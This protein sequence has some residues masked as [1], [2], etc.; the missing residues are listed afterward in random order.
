MLRLN[1]VRLRGCG[2]TLYPAARNRYVKEKY[3][4]EILVA[5]YSEAGAMDEDYEKCEQVERINPEMQSVISG[6]DMENLDAVLE[7]GLLEEKDGKY[8]LTQKCIEIL[9]EAAKIQNELDSQGFYCCPC[10]H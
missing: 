3:M 7:E 4:Q 10:A 8:A 1:D 5:I 9:E 2:F 6:S